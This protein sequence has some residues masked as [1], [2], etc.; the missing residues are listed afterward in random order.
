MAAGN[1]T[2]RL[3]AM[4]HA[5]LEPWKAAGVTLAMVD[6]AHLNWANYRDPAWGG[7]TPL[8][9]STM[10]L[11]RI[12]I[13]G[14]KLYY[15]SSVG[16]KSAKRLLRQEAALALISVVLRVHWVP[17]VDL[18]LA[19]SDRP[20]VPKSV[21]RPSQTPPL[22]FSYVR[23]SQHW[24]V[25][26]PYLSFAPGRWA[27]TLSQRGAPVQSRKPQALWRGACNSLCDEHRTVDCSRDPAATQ[28]VDRYRLLR[29]AARCPVL[30]DAGITR[31]HANCGR[32]TLR[33]LTAS[34]TSST[35]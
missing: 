11:T 32:T 24:S 34:S 13:I 31:R 18:V 2:S 30:V 14:G 26:F 23:T 3:E 22:V 1:A 21:L 16:S 5:Y 9:H 25:P 28:L 6:D 35:R 4:A 10:R 20:S 29:S 7:A 12:N 17:D 33:R 27:S 8:G 19:L 15:V